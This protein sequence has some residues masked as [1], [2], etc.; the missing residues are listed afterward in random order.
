MPGG[1]LEEITLEGSTEPTVAL[2]DYT[3]SAFTDDTGGY[4]NGRVFLAVIDTYIVVDDGYV[5]LSR[6]FRLR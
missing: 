5:D 3:L 4:I 6:S 1:V 2:E